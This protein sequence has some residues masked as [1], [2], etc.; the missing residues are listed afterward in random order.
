LPV[1]IML[2]LAGAAV[3]GVVLG[4]TVLD[5]DETRRG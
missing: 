5:D 1:L 4:R 2:T 3:G